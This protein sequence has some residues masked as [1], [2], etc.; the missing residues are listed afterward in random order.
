MALTNIRPDASIDIISNIPIDVNNVIDY[1][2]LYVAI[3]DQIDDTYYIYITP[4]IP[5]YI[6]EYIAPDLSIDDTYYIHITP[7]I[8]INNYIDFINIA[9]DIPIINI[10]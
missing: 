5:I 7:N 1:T 10:Y 4:N 9:A 8:P 3:N 6:I 2:T